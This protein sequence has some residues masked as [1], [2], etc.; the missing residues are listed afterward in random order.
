MVQNLREGDY[1]RFGRVEHVLTGVGDWHLGRGSTTLIQFEKSR[2]CYYKPRSGAIETTVRQFAATLVEVGAISSNF[3]PSVRLGNG[4]HLSRRIERAEQEHANLPN[5]YA[6]VGELLA[7]CVMIAADDLHYQNIVAG[8]EGPMVVDWETLGARVDSDRLPDILDAT[9]LLPN[10]DEHWPSS[11][12]C[13]GDPDSGKGDN[14][15]LGPEGPASITGYIIEVVSGAE[16]AA[17][18]LS[19]FARKHPDVIDRFRTAIRS[20]TA[21]VV[22]RP[23][24]IYATILSQARKSDQIAGSLNKAEFIRRA[25]DLHTMRYSEVDK[26]RDREYAA[27]Q[28]D[29]IP[30]FYV[31]G[32]TL[33]CSAGHIVRNDFS[34]PWD[35]DPARLLD[36]DVFQETLLRRLSRINQEPLQP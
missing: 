32:A 31:D 21:R 34:R 27:L 5:Y 9:R 19:S 17:R 22:V 12:L 26:L 14:L 23:T 20:A 29:M 16:R 33:F 24:H 11:G 18:A 25:L 13:G 15:P 2:S 36:L 8:S 28:A 10:L 3:C 7:F 6:A 1:G 35:I 30:S 4:F